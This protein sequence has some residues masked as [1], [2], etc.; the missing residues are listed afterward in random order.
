MSDAQDRVPPQAI[1]AEAVTLG[2]I[3]LHQPAVDVVRAVVAAEDFYRPAHQTIFRAIVEMHEA[4]K[5]LDLVT[6]REELT[7]R[8][9]LE[10]VGGIDYLVELVDGTPSAGNA[11]YYASLV[12]DRSLRRELIRLGSDT[13]TEG[14]DCQGTAA[15]KL[16]AVADRL[17]ALERQGDG[18]RESASDAGEGVGG[19]VSDLRTL[20]DTGTV[21]NPPLATGFLPFDKAQDGGPRR[22]ELIVIAGDTGSGKSTLAHNWA[23]NWCRDGLAGLIW[24][25]EM[26]DRECWQRIVSAMTGVPFTMIRS[27]TVQAEQH[28]RELEALEGAAKDWR[29]R[30]VGRPGKVGDVAGA[31]RSCAARWQRPADFI[32]V[33][34]LQDMVP[35]DAHANRNEQVGGMARACKRMAQ[36]LGAACILCSQLN[37]EGKATNRPTKRDLRDSGMI[38]DSA[39]TIILLAA[40]DDGTGMVECRFAK[41]RNGPSTLWEPDL[42][43]RRL[44]P[45]FRFEP[46]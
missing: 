2:A 12:R 3:L 5:P 7:A 46:T 9:Q 27:G 42:R 35:D 14:F 11:R 39:D 18:R 40:A 32:V 29:L 16:R 6:L 22:G 43:L 37:R 21:F 8:G 30:V 26:L 13:A 34:F 17:T 41:N 19:V 36:E 1:A 10:A 4:G 31:A 23:A 38:E 45:V 44:G 28:W 15:D 24:S 25:T 20:R 33:D